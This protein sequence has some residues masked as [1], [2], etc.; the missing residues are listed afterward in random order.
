MGTL[1][2]ELAD[3]NECA[4]TVVWLPPSPRGVPVP[5][6]WRFQHQSG[7]VSRPVPRQHLANWCDG[8][9]KVQWSAQHAF[10]LATGQKAPAAVGL[11]WAFF[12]SKLLVRSGPD[13]V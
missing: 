10:S 12:A 11:R 9:S 3:G 1:T 2:V 13:L 4:A 5:N 7:I 8:A 6:R